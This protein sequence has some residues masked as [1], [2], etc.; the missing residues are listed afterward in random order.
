[1]MEK[2][3]AMT[4]S[5]DPGEHQQFADDGGSFQEG[6]DDGEKVTKEVYEAE[7]L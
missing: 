5:S 1:M 3:T 7:R 6:Y 4:Y 2:R